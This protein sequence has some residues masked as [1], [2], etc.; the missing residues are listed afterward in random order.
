M[1]Y[2][3][4][5]LYNEFTNSLCL[6]LRTRFNPSKV[7]KMEGVA[8]HVFDHVFEESIHNFVI[9]KSSTVKTAHEHAIIFFYYF[10]LASHMMLSN[11]LTVH[12]HFRNSFENA[13]HELMPFSSN[14]SVF[15]CIILFGIV[16][17]ISFVVS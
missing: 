1:I 3:I 8:C 15:C 10:F 14:A 7:L 12:V 9:K 17:A 13:A 6:N 2:H 16:Y 5:V 4:D 11:L